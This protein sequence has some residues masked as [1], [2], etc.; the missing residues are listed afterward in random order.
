MEV[1]GESLSKT[2]WGFTKQTDYINNI[3][4][5]TNKIN[6]D[7]G[8]E[9]INDSNTEVNNEVK[10]SESRHGKRNKIVG[11]KTTVNSDCNADE[12]KEALETS[13]QNSEKL[14]MEGPSYE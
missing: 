2:N 1:R 11:F 12:V 8:Q 4:K 13:F 6:L 7:L 3:S 10:V 9:I 14:G 5:P